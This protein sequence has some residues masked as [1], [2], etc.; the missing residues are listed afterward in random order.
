[1]VLCSVAV[2]WAPIAA[3][4]ASATAG[5]EPAGHVASTW[6][7][8]CAPLTERSTSP[9]VLRSAAESQV[10][11]PVSTWAPAAGANST[12]TTSESAVGNVVNVSDVVTPK[13]PPPPPRS[14]QNRSG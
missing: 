6:Q 10:C 4:I 12:R 1:M 8:P 3:L 2:G 7:L 13:L 14:A 5:P 9:Q 11:Q